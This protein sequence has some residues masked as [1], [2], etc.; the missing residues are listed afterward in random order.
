MSAATQLSRKDYLCALTVVVIWGLNF[1]IMKIGLKGLSPMTLGAL[2]F[3]LAA[4]PLVL[5]VRPPRLPWQWIAAYGLVPVS[6][7][8]LDVYK[9]QTLACGR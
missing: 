9:R 3:A 4:F 2:R 1:V 7:T 6:Y 5:F 8:H